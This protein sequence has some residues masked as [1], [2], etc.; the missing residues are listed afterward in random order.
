MR[1]TPLLAFAGT[2]IVLAAAGCGGG[3][4]SPGSSA[5]TSSGG[6]GGA[7]P[8]KTIRIVEKE[9]SLTPNAISISKPGLYVLQG[10]NQ[11]TISHGIAIEGNGLDMDGP[12]VS[13]GSTSTIRVTI[14]KNGSYEVY[15]PVAGHKEM[16]MEGHV[17]LGSGGGSGT[18]TGED[19]G[20]TTDSSGGYGYG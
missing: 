7:T 17:T 19:N 13:P 9:Y 3:G 15:C 14:S 10:V 1:P 16:G 6:S 12:I 5:S 8:V 11:G 18:S 20:T 2:V 4:G